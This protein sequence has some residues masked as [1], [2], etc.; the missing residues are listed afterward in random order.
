VFNHH[1]SWTQSG[2]VR[3]HRSGIGRNREVK[4]IAAE[5]GGFVI[6]V[7]TDDKP[8]AHSSGQDRRPSRSPRPPGTHEP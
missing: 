6:E 3:D 4:V 1:D 2:G 8:T 7:T 5:A